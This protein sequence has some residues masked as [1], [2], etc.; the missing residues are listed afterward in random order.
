MNQ[1]INQ[2]TKTTSQV[3]RYYNYVP[4]LTSVVSDVDERGMS[5]RTVLEHRRCDDDRLAIIHDCSSCQ[6]NPRRSLT[7][8]F[9]C[10]V[11]SIACILHIRGTINA[12]GAAT[13]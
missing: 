5:R 9:P 7:A 1:S 10:R 12:I 4:T 6:S 11:V 3:L 2:R 8:S 13:F